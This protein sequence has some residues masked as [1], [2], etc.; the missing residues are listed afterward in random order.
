[1]NINV[2]QRLS[3][4]KQKIYYNLEWGKSASQPKSTGIFTYAEPK[5][6]VQKDHNKKALLILENTKSQMI[7]TFTF[8]TPRQSFYSITGTGLLVTAV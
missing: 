6:Q 1:M 4:N 7:T 3:R 8:M 2:T 5:D